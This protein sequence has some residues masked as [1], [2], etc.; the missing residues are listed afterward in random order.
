M[1][2]LLYRLFAE[3]RVHIIVHGH[4][5]LARRIL[6]RAQHEVVRVLRR[7]DDLYLIAEI[8]NAALLV[9]VIALQRRTVDMHLLL[10]DRRV[11]IVI[12]AE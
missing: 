2:H 6:L 7:L 8:V 1:H 9:I 4:K 5:L 12:H 10:V 3:V 11:R